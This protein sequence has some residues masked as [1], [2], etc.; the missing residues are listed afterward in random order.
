MK[1]LFYTKKTLAFLFFCLGMTVSLSAQF[2]QQ[3]SKLVGTGNSGTAGQGRSVALS[4][5]GNTALVGG[6]SDNSGQGAVWVYTRSGSTWTQQGS[7]LVGTGNSGGAAQGHSVAL[8]SDGNTALVGGLLDNSNQGAVWVFTRS[9]STWTQQGSKL[10]GTGNSG[11]AGQGQSVALSSD[12]NTAL[13]GGVYDNS[14][15]GAV[16]VYTRSG[17]TWTQQGSKLVGTGNT[18]TAGQGQSVA[19]SSDGNTALVGGVTDDSGQG[20]VWVFTRSG[21]TWTQQGSKLVGTGNTGGAS[22][23]QSVALSSDGNTAL[24][25]AYI[26]NGAQGAAWVFMRSGLTW[27]QQGA[28]LVG[29]GNTG[30]ALQGYSVALSGDGNTALVGGLLDDSNQGAAWAFYNSAV[31]PVEMLDFTGKHTKAGNLLTWITANEENNKGFQVERLNGNDWQ[32]IGFKTANNKSSTYDFTDNNPLPITSGSA[33]STSYYRLRQIDN[34]GKETFS[35]VISISSKGSDKLKVY[36]NPVSNVLT[37]ETTE[38][39][40]FQILNL[41]GQQVLHGKAPFGGWGL[42]VSALPQGTYF[43]KIGAE[44]VKFVKQ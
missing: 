19:L 16:W 35:K 1:Y 25:G 36:P 30:V 14:G 9:G 2:T 39:S 27:T 13:V 3:G 20:A 22:Q 32:N 5:D 42:D 40:D 43:L 29:T 6:D 34:D 8:S 15:Q 28:K 17:S 26:D 44:Q 11:G 31:L 23:G 7:K 41:L 33:I 38:T 12:G 4:S 10:V 37:V 24:V 21:S 18:G